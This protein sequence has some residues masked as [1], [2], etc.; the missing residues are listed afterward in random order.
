MFGNINEVWNIGL[1][2]SSKALPASNEIIPPSFRE[3]GSKSDPIIIKKEGSHSGNRKVSKYEEIPMVPD[4][5]INNRS[6]K[7]SDNNT[8]DKDHPD[9]RCNGRFWET[10][11]FNLYGNNNTLHHIPETVE[12]SKNSNRDRKKDFFRETYKVCVE[13]KDRRKES[14]NKKVVLF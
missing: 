8:Y 13:D 10:S 1:H 9:N 7:G 3:E 5:F 12:K 6:E 2:R 11:F 14:D 4:F